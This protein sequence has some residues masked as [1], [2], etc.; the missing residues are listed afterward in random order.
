MPRILHIIQAGILLY[1][2]YQYFDLGRVEIHR[3]FA[4]VKLIKHY[5]PTE[6][7]NGGNSKTYF[8]A[9]DVTMSRDFVK[10]RGAIATCSDSNS[11]K[12]QVAR[13]LSLVASNWTQTKKYVCS[14]KC[15]CRC[16]VSRV[17]R[18]WTRLYKRDF[19]KPGICS[20][21]KP[22]AMVNWCNFPPKSTQS[23]YNM[24]TK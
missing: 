11:R 19:L 9:D 18:N 16:R 10:S 1:K 4:W 14:E 7:V 23:C 13:D 5:W 17:A 22:A 8:S 12:R 21:I 6:S 24:W 3:H 15:R 20:L 2:S